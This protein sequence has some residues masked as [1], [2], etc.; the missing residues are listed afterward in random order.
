MP[1]STSSSDSRLP[2]GPWA[3]TW[4]L[5]AI[6]VVGVLAIWEVGLR[7]AGFRPSVDYA[8][9][10]VVARAHVDPRSTVFLG[11]SRIQAALVPSAWQE[12][13]GGAAPAQL[14]WIGG[15]PLPMIE[16]FAN[17]STFRGL[18]IVDLLPLH[19]FDVSGESEQQIIQGIEKWTRDLPSPARM[20]ENRL[21]SVVTSAFAFRASPAA[22]DRILETLRAGETPMPQVSV[23]NADRW[24]PFDYGAAVF[25][26]RPWDPEDGFTH[27]EYR[28]A[29]R[30]GRVPDDAEFTALLDRYRTAVQRIHERGGHVVFV[31]LPVCGGRRDVEEARYP[32]QRFWDVFAR[33]VPGVMIH[34]DDEPALPRLPCWDGSHIAQEYAPAVTRD[35][36][37]LVLERIADR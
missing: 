23:L 22:P 10:W 9:S 11:T 29:E 16:E 15:S 18:L 27:V 20:V 6:L 37:E 21:E 35:L 34:W 17:D 3:R 31:V 30:S 7:A 24:S 8:A 36:A 4:R 13:A 2:P 12:V 5:T 28:L 1:S 32:R 19:A 26:G 14:A 25:D 33:R